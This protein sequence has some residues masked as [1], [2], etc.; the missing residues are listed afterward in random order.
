MCPPGSCVQLSQQ[1]SRALKY[2]QDNFLLEKQLLF[3][4][5]FPTRRTK[6]TLCLTPL[7]I[8]LP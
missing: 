6:E 7:V 2:V 5:Y 4:T 3:Q 1:K 8:A